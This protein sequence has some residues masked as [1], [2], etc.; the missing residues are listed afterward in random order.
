MRCSTY[1]AEKQ[2]VQIPSLCV[3]LEGK[4]PGISDAI[5]RP[6]LP[7]YRRETCEKGSLFAILVQECSVGI[8]GDVLCWIG[9][10]L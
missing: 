8:V 6:P 3:H 2:P 1:S 5:C 7:N 4:P 9:V 10:T